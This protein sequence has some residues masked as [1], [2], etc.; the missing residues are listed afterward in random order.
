MKL[1]IIFQTF[2]QPNK[3]LNHDQSRPRRNDKL[4]FIGNFE[5]LK[6]CFLNLKGFVLVF[7]LT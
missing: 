5:F 6:I 3:I 1:Q 4:K 7:I 2:F